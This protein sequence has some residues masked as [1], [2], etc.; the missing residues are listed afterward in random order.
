MRVICNAGS[1]ACALPTAASAGRVTERVQHDFMR[2]L[3]A[4][5]TL[6][7][8]LLTA[9]AWPSGAHAAAG[10]ANLPAVMPAMN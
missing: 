3:L 5:F 2:R 7:V 1:L 9:M 8:S 10:L 6:L 4:A